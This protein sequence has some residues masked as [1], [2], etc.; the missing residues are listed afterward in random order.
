MYPALENRSD[1]L[2]MLDEMTEA[3]KK[4]LDRCGQL[5]PAQL[6]DPV[7]PGTWSLFQNL[8]HLAW[9]EA[10]MLAW[11]KKRPAP[12]PKEEHPPMPAADLAVLRTAFDEAHAAT[13]AFLKTGPESVLKERCLY[14]RQGE[15]TV[16]GVLWHLIEHEIHHRAFINNKLEKLQH[17]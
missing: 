16:G 14:S 6:N 13:I 9:A 3:R 5:M 1:I 8:T 2:K 11:I 17:P 4:F 15:Q 7:Y 10:W 12:L